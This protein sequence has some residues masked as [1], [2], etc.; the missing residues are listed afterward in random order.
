MHCASKFKIAASIDINCANESKTFTMGENRCFPA[1]IFAF[2]IHPKN[3]HLFLSK[4]KTLRNK[5]IQ[6]LYAKYQAQM[7][8]NIKEK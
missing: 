4:T 7:K 2:N 8:S 6:S 1:Q 3:I 5:T